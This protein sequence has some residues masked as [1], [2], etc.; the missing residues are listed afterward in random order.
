VVLTTVRLQLER[1]S[2]GAKMRW[3]ESGA[4]DEPFGY[5]RMRVRIADFGDRPHGD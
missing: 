5:D 3:G 4:V 2:D 1:V